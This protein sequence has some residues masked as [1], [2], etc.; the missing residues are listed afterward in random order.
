MV[1]VLRE[2][3]GDRESVA[4]L[5]ALAL[6][7]GELL[8]V[9][10]EL[11]DG[12][13]QP[14]TV[15]VAAPLT[16]G[17]S[18]PLSRPVAEPLA[19]GVLEALNR[20][21]L[22]TVAV[23]K[24]DTVADSEPLTE[25]D[26][27]AEVVRVGVRDAT[28]ERDSEL[29]K[30]PVAGALLVAESDLVE[31]GVA[32]PLADCDTVELELGQ[33]LELALRL[34]LALPELENALDPLTVPVV[35]PVELDVED[36]PPLGEVATDREV[37]PLEVTRGDT[38]CVVLELEQGDTLREAPTLLLTRR[39]SEAA[40][41]TLGDPVPLLLPVELAD[42]RALPEPL[43][44]A[45]PVRDTPGERLDAGLSDVDGELVGDRVSAVV[46]LSV[47]ATLWVGVSLDDISAE[48]VS[49]GEPVG[50][51]LARAEAEALSERAPLVVGLA[52]AD[53]LPVADEL[54]TA[55]RVPAP[56]V[57]VAWGLALGVADCEFIADAEVVTDAVSTAVALDDTVDVCVSEVRGEADGKGVALRVVSDERDAEAD[58]VEDRDAG[59]ERV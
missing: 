4:V 29:Y 50:L 35:E 3:L 37:V 23:V 47:A 48:G 32:V 40:D 5:H 20:G 34:V 2:G 51:E 24:G 41:E 19:D 1:L 13:A 26:R 25:G 57:F 16:D 31:Q 10:D 36:A 44:D 55:L 30:L 38:D 15:A 21:D 33:E 14:L 11:T 58:G 27:V 17:T 6:P 45:V 59:G 18:E 28:G 39:D 52:E 56:A 43:T 54:A 8:P 46:R 9:C 7:R 42:A 12:D 49:L 53:A 22:D